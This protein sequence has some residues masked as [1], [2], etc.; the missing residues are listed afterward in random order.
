MG[1]QFQTVLK[2]IQ[3]LRDKILL[4][5]KIPVFKILKFAYF[6]QNA[7]S[8]QTGFSLK[9]QSRNQI[10]NSKTC[11]DEKNKSEVR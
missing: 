5:F 2:K 4:S 10:K 1:I 7:S 8:S 9:T 11:F 3:K 6:Y